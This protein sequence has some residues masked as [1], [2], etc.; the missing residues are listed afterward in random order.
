MG[1]NDPDGRLAGGTLKGG[2]LYMHGECCTLYGVWKMCL[3][4]MGIEA[5]M[6]TEITGSV[7]HIVLRKMLRMNESWGFSCIVHRKM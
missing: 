5:I 2:T 6:K 4:G 3:L 7:H 1:L